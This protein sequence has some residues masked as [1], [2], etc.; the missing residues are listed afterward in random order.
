MCKFLQKYA[1]N[2]IKI[3]VC[4]FL[5]LIVL[6][7]IDMILPYVSGI[8]IDHLVNDISVR[9]ISIFL[10]FLAFINIIKVIGQYSRTLLNTKLNNTIIYQIS[11][12]IFQKI[13][14]TDYKHYSNIDCAYQ[15]DKINR[16][17]NI[18]VRF[19]TG[20]IVN[21]I[22]QVVTIILCGMILYQSDIVLCFVVFALLPIYI[23]TFYLNKHSMYS[24]HSISKEKNNEYFSIYMEQLL[25]LPHV[26][27]NTLFDEM[28]K[29]L[30]NAYIMSSQAVINSVKVD[31]IF[32]NLNQVIIV[33]VYLCIVG[34]GGY[35]VSIGEL[36]I[37]YFSIINIYFNM[38]IRSIAYF[39]GLVSTYQDAKVSYNRLS[40]INN[41]KYEINGNLE[42]DSINRVLADCIRIYGKNIEFLRPFTYEFE[43]GKI[44]GIVGTN[45]SGKTTLLNALLGLY[46]AEYSGCIKYNN[47]DIQQFNLYNI[48]KKH[49]SYV[50]QNPI[51][52]NMSVKEYLKFG[53]TS[54]EKFIKR[55]NKLIC[56][57]NVEYLLSKEINENGNNLSGGEKQK[58]AL[59]KAFSKESSLILLDEPSSALDI[60]SIDVLLSYLNKRK[61]EA[62][63]IL[64][65]HDLNLIKSCDDIIELV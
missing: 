50:E 58:L 49:I 45:G 54:D 11:R 23:A 15:I 32:T 29:R 30:E 64:V 62:I 41:K 7:S 57:F 21:F 5:V 14:R 24:A 19:F 51:M 10:L 34:I 31:Y 56:K 35:K 33:I 2:N 12:D 53:C 60:K 6:W 3:L 61:N 52:F 36:S 4:Y 20:N 42:L 8:Y 48:R 59:I 9:K 39:L 37:G 43:K 46:S 27:R 63:I 40:A 17:T 38:I 16:D 26:K 22:L 28:N 25:K 18:L 44:Y 1:R 55:Q 47:V 13:F 65:T